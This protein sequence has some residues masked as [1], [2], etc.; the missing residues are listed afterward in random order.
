MKRKT[1][2]PVPLEELNRLPTAQ[3]LARLQSLRQCEDSLA[4]SDQMGEGENLPGSIPFKESAEW[5]E[6]YQQLKT[7]LAQREHIVKGAQLVALRKEKAQMQRTTD[8]KI[9]KR[10]L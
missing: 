10:Q 1:I 8:R 3:L 2:F 5:A 7:V 6:A 4:A 9:G